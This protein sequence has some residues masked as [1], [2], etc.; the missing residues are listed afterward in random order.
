[1]TR[2]VWLTFFGSYR[3]DAHAWD[4]AHESPPSMTIPLVILAALS[5]A[6][7]WIGIPA[8][9]SAGA[10]PNVLHDWLAPA[11]A[12]GAGH[13]GAGAAAAHHDAAALELGLIGLALA[14]AIAGILLATSIY[15]R[16]G[17]AE[18]IA[19]TA[20]PFY[21]LVRNLYWVD[22]LYDAVVIRPFY[23]VSRFFRG[24]DRWIVDGLVNASGVVTELTGQVIKLFQTG[25]VRNYALLFLLGVVAILCYLTL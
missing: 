4:E 10:I 19:A 7:G 22:E 9:L 3:G 21:V 6:G 5:V 24:F 20:G 14:I 12:G 18:R 17:K 13:H 2:L 25:L 1:M 8:V 23:A 16:P 15:R 11:F